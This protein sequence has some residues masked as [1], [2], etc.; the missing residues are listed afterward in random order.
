[1]KG[2]SRHRKALLLV[3]LLLSAALVLV[4][5]PLRPEM[6]AAVTTMGPLHTNGVDSVIYNSSNEP[7]RLVGFN[8]T[9]MESGGAQRLPEGS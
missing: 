9:G 4:S 8:W 3:Q 6:A 2:L 5:A 7:V 1:M